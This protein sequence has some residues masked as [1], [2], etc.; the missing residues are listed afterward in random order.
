[1]EVELSTC[2][3]HPI[4]RRSVHDNIDVEGQKSYLATFEARCMEELE[5]ARL[6][7]A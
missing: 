7:E 1:M 6:T 4:K 2:R 3:Y 5:N